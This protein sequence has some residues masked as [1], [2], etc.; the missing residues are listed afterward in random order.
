[1]N[2]HK[3]KTNFCGFLENFSKIKKKIKFLYLSLIIKEIF[4]LILEKVFNN[5]R[6]ICNLLKIN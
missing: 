2:L 1:M 3:L 6:I 5:S 4:F